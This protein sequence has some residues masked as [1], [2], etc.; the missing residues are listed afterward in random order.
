M[1]T[2]IASALLLVALMLPAGVAAADEDASL[3]QMVVEM[4]KTPAE[5]AALAAHFR[6]EA[7]EARAKGRRHEAMARAYGQGKQRSRSS[8]SYHCKRLSERYVEMASEYDE[9]AKLHDAE[10]RQAP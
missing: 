2:R 6:A 9:L 10:S 8:G 5:H 4:A 7:E 1:T 3:E